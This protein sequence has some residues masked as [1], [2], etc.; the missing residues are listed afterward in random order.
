VDHPRIDSAFFDA[1]G[2]HA[3]G[4]RIGVENA[5]HMCRVSTAQLFG[6]EELE[7]LPNLVS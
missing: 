3:G 7:H 6:T 4:D 2:D 5:E 1:R